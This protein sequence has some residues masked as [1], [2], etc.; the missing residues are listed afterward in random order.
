MYFFSLA[1]EYAAEVEHDLGGVVGES[2]EGSVCRQEGDDVGSLVGF[3]IL[4]ERVVLV[5]RDVGLD[6]E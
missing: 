4:G 1:L 2:L 5:A 6:D 3:A